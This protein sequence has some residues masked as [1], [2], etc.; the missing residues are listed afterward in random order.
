MAIIQMPEIL[1]IVLFSII[2]L[3]GELFSVVVFPFNLPS[4]IFNS[5]GAVFLVKF[6]LD[7]FTFMDRTIKLNINFPYEIIFGII[8]FWVF[9][10]V[11]IVGY[12]KIFSRNSKRNNKKRYKR[13]RK[14]SKN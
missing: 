9:M 14:S 11:L 10:I 1:L 8:G 2:L 12:I 3:F 5:I 4:P 6:L 7:L 13:E